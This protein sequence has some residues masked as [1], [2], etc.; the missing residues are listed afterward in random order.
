MWLKNHSKYGKHVQ[1]III[2]RDFEFELDNALKD[3]DLI[4]SCI[5]RVKFGNTHFE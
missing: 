4:G 2:F 5:C 1:D 3:I